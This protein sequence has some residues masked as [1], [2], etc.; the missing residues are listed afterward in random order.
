MQ[1]E[2]EII[3]ADAFGMPDD[4]TIV[5]NLHSGNVDFP[6]LLTNLHY[7]VIP[8]GSADSGEQM[9]I[10]TGPFTLRSADVDGI[11]V[12]DARTDYWNGSPMLGGVTVV[13]IADADARVSATLAGQ[14]DMTSAN[15]T[16]AQASLFEGD[17][18]FYIQENPRG[19]LD[20]M[21][22]ITTEPPFDDVRVRQALKLALDSQEMIDIVLQGHGVPACSNPALSTDQYYLPLDC[23]QDVEGARALLAEAGYP[24]G[25]TIEFVT[26]N[27]Y[28]QWIPIATVYKEQA[29]KAGIN[30][31]IRE[32]SAEGFWSEVWMV[33]P[34]AHSLWGSRHIDYFMAAGFR[35]GAA[36]NETF[37][38]NEEFDALQDQARATLDFDARKALYQQ[39]QQLI[40]DDG[41]MMTPFFAN[42]IRAVNIRLQGVP[43]IANRGEY[44]YHE[45]RI[46]EP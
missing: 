5:Y 32:A 43:E 23:P 27:M 33:E 30:I 24:D 45:F 37:W 13:S 44:P 29:A 35:C 14:V 40:A 34:F 7:L 16:A 1:K 3:D 41:G 38:C 31:E 17:P 8:D 6:L 42:R 39:A 2:L 25:I 22:M 4:R 20:M 11:T 26:A 18:D 12:F 46:V 28:P 10:G 9:P 36:W 15:L 19:Q 21:V